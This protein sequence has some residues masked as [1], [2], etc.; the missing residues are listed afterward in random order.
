MV[1]FIILVQ[2]EHASESSGGLIKTNCW[3]TPAGVAELVGLG[4]AWG[5]P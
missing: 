4:V 3:A 5:L 2:N 1:Y